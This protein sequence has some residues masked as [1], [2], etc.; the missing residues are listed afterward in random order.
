[1]LKDGMDLQNTERGICRHSHRVH[2]HTVRVS[3][4]IFIEKENK[5][6]NKFFSVKS[7]HVT[8]LDTV[9]KIQN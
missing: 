2:F 7:G 8:I 4:E 3:I 1:M 5:T 9:N 6:F